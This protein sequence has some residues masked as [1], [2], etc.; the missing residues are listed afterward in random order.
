MMRTTLRRPRRQ[1]I[2]HGI[3][4]ALFDWRNAAKGQNPALELLHAIPNGAALKHGI[5]R[6]LSG[7][8]VRYSPEGKSLRREGL[9]ASIPD[10]SWPVARGCYH[11]LYIEHKAPKKS[12]PREQRAMHLALREQGYYV[13]VSRDAQLS[14]DLLKAYWALG[15]FDPAGGALPPYEK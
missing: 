10:V 14:I 9:T 1:K 6:T 3:Q 13:A 8:N 15:P 7:K 11:G 5:R 4:V 12:V 2:E